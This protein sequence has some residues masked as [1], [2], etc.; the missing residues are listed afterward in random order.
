MAVKVKKELFEAKFIFY[1][2]CSLNDF[3]E[4]LIFVGRNANPC[5]SSVYKELTEADRERRFTQET[6]KSDASDLQ[7]GNWY[8]FTGDAGFKLSNR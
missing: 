4:V 1:M 8:R 5:S 6:G 2:S 7:A 3:T